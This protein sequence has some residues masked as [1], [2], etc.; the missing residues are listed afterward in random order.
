ME[1]LALAGSFAGPLGKG[2]SRAFGLRS[3]TLKSAGQTA[4]RYTLAKDSRVRLR[5]YDASGETVEYVLIN[6][7]QTAGPKEIRLE[8]GNYRPGTYLLQLNASGRS[9][10]QLIELSGPTP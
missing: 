3:V 6:G 1:A 5:L 8:A 7:T 4:I 9:A 2:T 10:S